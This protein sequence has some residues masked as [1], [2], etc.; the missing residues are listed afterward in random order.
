MKRLVGTAL[1]VC[2]ILSTSGF[3]QGVDTVFF[4]SKGFNSYGLRIPVM[5]DFTGAGA[6][7]EGMGN[8]FFAVSDDVSALSWNPAGLYGQ[9]KPVLGFSYG[10]F[11]P[12][13]TFDI[14]STLNP[15]NQTYNRD[16][17]FNGLTQL[18]FLSPIRIKGHPFVFAASYTRTGSDYDF[19]NIRFDTTVFLLDNQGVMYQSPF[20]LDYLSEYNS[21]LDVINVGF[22]TRLSS[23]VSFGAAVNIYTNESTTQQEQSF[24]IDSIFVGFPPQAQKLYTDTLVLDTSKY[25]GVTIT[26]GLKY[27]SEKWAVGLVFRKPFTLQQKT[28]RSVFASMTANGLEIAGQTEDVHFDRIISKIDMP[29]LVGAGASVNL[30]EN[31]V[32]AG[33]FEYQPFSGGV[34]KL[35]EQFQIIPG[36]KDV[37]VFSTHDPHWNNSWAIRTGTEY[38]FK[39]NSDLITA[40]P[41]RAGFSYAQSPTVFVATRSDRFGYATIPVEDSAVVSRDKIN[42]WALSLGAG[43]RFQQIQLDMAYTYSSAN[44]DHLRSNLPVTGTLESRNNNFNFTFIGYF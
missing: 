43:I 36:E 18:S 20:S 38:V 2:L 40:V 4:N 16:R 5:F 25:S 21:A 19:F 23:R 26:G 34:V 8:A 15:V 39:T 10:A 27:R 28:N 22:G 41:V 42:Q 44:L 3:G 35:R 13:G 24:T 30:R 31:W 17:T 6:R 11:A 32:W 12:G 14:S 33:D 29:L 7:A 9:G 37:E 1:G